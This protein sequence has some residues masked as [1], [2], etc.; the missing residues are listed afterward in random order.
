MKRIL[1]T[2]IT[3]LCLLAVSVCPV[4]AATSRLVDDADLL[5][6]EEARE[7]EQ[8][9]DEV[10]QRHR[11]DVVVVTTDALGGLTP[12]EY[13]DDCYDY[14]GYSTDGILLL[15]SMEDSDWWISTAGYGITAFTDAGIT[16]ISDRV[17]PYLSDGEY[18]QAFLEFAGLCD[19]FITQA[20][21]GDPYDS[22]NLPKEPFSVVGSLVVALIVGLIAA[23]IVTGVMKGQLKTVHQ[24]TKADAYVVAGS[25][26]LN[27]SRDLF[28][29]TKL[30]KREKTKSS[31]GSSTHTSSSGTTHGGGGGKF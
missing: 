31:S 4:L 14:N 9:L 6:G 20:E 26:Q 30:D 16:Y 10:S 27:V 25:L 24:Q 29:Y 15:V 1:I 23:L 11:I 8:L 7:V 18:A 28:L 17:V 2:W 3:V 5:S 19:D 21:S 13:A 12:M 22:H